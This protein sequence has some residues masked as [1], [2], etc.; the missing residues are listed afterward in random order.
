MTPGTGHA[1]P[2]YAPGIGAIGWSARLD[3][4]RRNAPKLATWA[5]PFVLVVYLGLK[6]G[7]Y[8]SIVRGEVGVAIWWIVL[9]LA[10]VGVLPTAGLRRN[11]WIG[12][13]L[14][15]GF[16]LWTGL[17]ISW[18]GN[19]EASVTE[20]ARVLTYLGVFVLVLSIRQPGDM[21]RLVHGLAAGIVVIACF[22]LLSR[23]QPD[24][25][26][27]DDTGQILTSTR[28]RLSYP[29]DYWNGLAA[30]M[31]MAM[32]LLLAISVQARTVAGRAAAGAALP[33]VALTAFVTFSRGG[34]IEV[35]LALIVFLALAPNRLAVLPNLAVAVAGSA[36]LI[37]GT[38]QRQAVSDGLAT[39][40]AQQQGDEL[41][42][43]AI[44]VC[45]GVALLLAAIGL[46]ARHGIGPRVKVPRHVSIPATLLVV[47]VAAAVALAAGLPG[48]LSTRWEDFKTVGPGGGGVGV[49]R[50][51]NSTGSGRY[52]T[53]TSARDAG[54]GE[55]VTGIGPGTFQDYWAQKGTLPIFVR[56][57]HSLY[58]E[59]LGELGVTGMLLITGFIVWVLAL[60][61]RRAL[62]G[63]AERRW[64]YAA[65]TA[66]AAAF[67][68]AAGIDWAW[69]LSVLPIAFVILAAG[70]LGSR[71]YRS[72]NRQEAWVTRTI[73]IALGA[74]ALVAIA[75]P[76]LGAKA[77]SDSRAD[78]RAGDL[79]AAL[80]GARH[81]GDLQPYAATPKLQEALV[82]EL[83]GDFDAAA[84][85]AEDAT[86]K[87][88]GD[89]RTW[90]ILSRLQAERHDP[91]A[92]VSAY[93]HARTLNPR[94]PLFAPPR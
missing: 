62:R 29:L 39:S 18:S 67:A 17:G 87:A 72:P 80:D 35:A 66:S 46:A 36:I 11:G 32:P 14:L 63:E 86:H 8:N 47:V 27:A 55:P 85:A 54:K 12:L 82:L 19:S 56:D 79:S 13:G 64:P 48:Y 3:G 30:L 68:A 25:F 5:L 7:G 23:L 16:A 59:S 58:M 88:S 81:A 57:A 70:L 43:M 69:E 20:F 76:L 65:A 84:A 6:G 91:A 45:A 42:A 50:F 60:G 21:R 49:T 51:D 61:A 78:A 22:A 26:P 28:S 75:L 24:W 94:S 77:V 53:W 83:M 73:L 92:A 40:A 71:S 15:A 4:L 90:L 74:V 38:N 89:W 31:A 10:A 52:Q 33:L 1:E 44:V 9:L 34:A 37:V 93:R 41:L 2:I